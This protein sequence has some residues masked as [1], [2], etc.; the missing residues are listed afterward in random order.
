MT[1]DIL[2][3]DDDPATIR[4]LSKILS[5][6]GNL[7]FAANGVDALRM[8]RALAPDLILLDAEMPGLSGFQVCEALKTDPALADIPVIFVTSHTGLD[9]EVSSLELGAADF[10]AKPVSP[11]VVLARVKAQLRIK[12]MADELRHIASTDALTGI[13]NRRRFDESLEREWRL[14]RRT[15]DALALLMIDIDHFKPFNDRYGHPA[16]D[17]CLR[18]V[19][20]AIVKAS[21]R[22]TDFAARYGGEEFVVLLPK[23]PRIGAEHVARG[24]LGAVESLAIAHEGS[25]TATIVTV[26]I[27]VAC[28]DGDG[29]C[30]TSPPF[31]RGFAGESRARQFATDLVDGADRALYAAK[32]AGRDRACSLDMAE[33]DSIRPTNGIAH[34]PT[35][36]AWQD[37]I[38]I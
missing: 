2:L 16:G 14:A 4:L 8:A 25:A 28:L 30:R 22:P 24:I 18:S 29:A 17:A 13:A 9:F 36:G 11:G 5:R 27:G 1:E 35:N 20:Q 15:G 33:I 19:A 32:H 3:V 21:L 6:V 23:T 34:P 38:R 12:R 26:S 7:S 37:G 10:I 31:D